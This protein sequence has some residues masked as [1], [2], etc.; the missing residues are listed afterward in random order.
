MV[1]KLKDKNWE[2]VFK[3]TQ[4]IAETAE[5]FRTRDCRLTREASE[6]MEYW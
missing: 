5:G 2:S 1:E 4:R 6:A 3:W